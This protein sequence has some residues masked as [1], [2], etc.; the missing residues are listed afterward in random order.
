[1]LVMLSA[2]R[3]ISFLYHVVFISLA[4]IALFKGLKDGSFQVGYIASVFY[5]F[6]FA[7]V[8][9]IGWSGIYMQSWNFL[10]GV[11]RIL[12]VLFITILMYLLV[13][14]EKQLKLIYR[15]ILLCYVIAA[16]SIIY[17][18]IFGPISWFA[19]QFVRANLDRYSSIL[20]SL[21]IFGSVVGYGLLMLYSNYL[22]QKKL[23]LKMLLFFILFS[24]AVFSLTKA[25]VVMVGISFV[26]FLIYDFKSILKRFRFINLIFFISVV[27]ILFALLMQIHEFKEYY[28]VIVTQTIGGSS[29]LSDGTGVKMDSDSVSY[30]HI[31]KRLFHFTSEMFKFYG[32]NVVYS[33]VGLQGGAGTLGITNN[34]VHY[35]S[36]HNALGDLFFIGGVFYL[37]LFL[38]LF[39]STQI[40]FLKQKDDLLCRLLF[41]LNILFFANLLA[42]S[43]SVFHPAI[44]LPFWISTV[45][46]NIKN[47]SS[48]Q[49]TR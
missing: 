1:M 31:K 9:V 39:C 24:A 30:D 23:V 7:T 43:G 28:N 11:P 41:M 8:L 40:V 42:A 27:T 29:F 20:G 46:A 47:N 34:G 45:Y 36:A 17:Q 14:T 16:L 13:K 35:I 15:L 38:V 26:V 10:P 22:I 3:N 12:L 19:P 32:P 21:T 5:L 48:Q 4:V 44:S 49:N 33:G 6:V 2:F 25:G 37:I 18:I